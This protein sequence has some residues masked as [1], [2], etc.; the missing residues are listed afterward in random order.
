MKTW[1]FRGVKITHKTGS[2]WDATIG[3][4]RCHFAS[5][6]GAKKFIREVL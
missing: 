1:T 5:L 4:I 3:G 2:T 6:N